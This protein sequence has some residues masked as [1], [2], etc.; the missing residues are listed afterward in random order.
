MLVVLWHLPAGTEKKK[1]EKLNQD[2]WT[3]QLT[4]VKQGSYPSGMITNI[5]YHNNDTHTV[6]LYRFKDNFRTFLCICKIQGA[7]VICC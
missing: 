2:N 1:H 6:G 3:V 5:T 4:N 7:W